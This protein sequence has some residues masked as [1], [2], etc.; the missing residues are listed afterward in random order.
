MYICNFYQ[1]KGQICSTIFVFKIKIC[2][3]SPIGVSLLTPALAQGVTGGL[4]A[5]GAARGARK[6][7]GGGQ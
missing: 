3:Y 6:T 4:E 1:K 7:L 2:V 5:V